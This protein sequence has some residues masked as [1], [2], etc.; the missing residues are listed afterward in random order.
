MDQPVF[1]FFVSQESVTHVIVPYQVLD[2]NRCDTT[3][4]IDI[5][6]RSN[7]SG[8]WFSGQILQQVD[9]GRTHKGRT[10]MVLST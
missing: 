7:I 6:G 8:S 10:T 1:S 9:Q 4:L 3:T 2:K 5:I